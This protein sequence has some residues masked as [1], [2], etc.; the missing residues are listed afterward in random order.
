MLLFLQG[1]RLRLLN[2]LLEDVRTLDPGSP[3][4]VMHLV[5]LSRELGQMYPQERGHFY[6]FHFVRMHVVEVDAILKACET[7]FEIAEPLLTVQDNQSVAKAIETLWTIH[8]FTKRR[9]LILCDELTR[10][11][12]RNF[13]SSIFFLFN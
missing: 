10:K 8:Y 13:F 9:G 4:Y 5:N 2:L 1:N 6:E 11:I 7:L 3:R 12:V